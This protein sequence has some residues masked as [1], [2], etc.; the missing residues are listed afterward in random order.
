M[1]K[2]YICAV[3]GVIIEYLDDMHGVTMKFKK[4]NPLEVRFVVPV[5]GRSVAGRKS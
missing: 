2:F 4:K 5:T 3:V 1:C